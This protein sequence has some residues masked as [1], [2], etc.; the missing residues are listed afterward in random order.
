M[1]VDWGHV[2]EWLKDNAG[3]GAAL[4]GSLI[5]GNVPTA[6]AAGVSLVSS[7][8]GHATPDKALAALQNSPETVVKLQ[9]LANQEQDSIRKHIEEMTRLDLQDKQA[10]QET[11]SKTI[12]SGDNSSDIMVRRTRPGLAIYG[13]VAATLYVIACV[14]MGTAVDI[15]V[16]LAFL[17]LPYAYMGLRQVGKGIDSISSA[18]A[19]AKTATVPVGK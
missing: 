13:T 2:G 5:T 15:K 12:I 1:N 16:M 17:S 7:A 9:E 18:V 4:V 3:T 6:V 14:A 8:T 11:T 19:I 10:E